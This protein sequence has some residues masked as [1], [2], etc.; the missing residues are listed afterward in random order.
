M[1]SKPAH[2]GTSITAHNRR[3]PSRLAPDWLAGLVVFGGIVAMP[4][5]IG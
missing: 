5:V 4:F 3:S 1:L 2:L